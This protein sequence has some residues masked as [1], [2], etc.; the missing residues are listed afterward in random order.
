MTSYE[1]SAGGV[2][3]LL[4]LIEVDRK[5]GVG[6]GRPG[7]KLANKSASTSTARPQWWTAHKHTGGICYDCRIVA[8][9]AA[10]YGVECNTLGGAPEVIEHGSIK[11]HSAPHYLWGHEKDSEPIADILCVKEITRDEL[12]EDVLSRA[13]EATGGLVVVRRYRKNSGGS[14]AFSQHILW[15]S[16]GVSVGCRTDYKSTKTLP[17][18]RTVS[19][20]GLAE[21]IE[22]SDVPIGANPLAVGRLPD[23][24][25]WASKGRAL[26][27]IDDLE[28]ARL[29]LL[30]SD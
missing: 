27:T 2:D 8:S 5:A 15:K 23:D 26:W 3:R 6:F 4:A 28:F 12:P 20:M 17:G 13:P 9:L 16:P 25:D 19:A 30:D 14:Y 7:S 11:V 18:G 1:S 21:L 22:V 24:F 10:V 29:V